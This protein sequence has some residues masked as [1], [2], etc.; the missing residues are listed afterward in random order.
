MSPPARCS[1]ALNPQAN[2][3]SWRSCAHQGSNGNL[4]ALREIDSRGA[5]FLELTGQRGDGRLAADSPEQAWLPVVNKCSSGRNG[6][7]CASSRLSTPRVCQTGFV[8]S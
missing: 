4:Q 6:S 5:S 1:G 3:R 2:D 8:I 7:S